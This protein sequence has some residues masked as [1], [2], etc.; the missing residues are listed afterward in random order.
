MI[1]D[2][3]ATIFLLIR[4]RDGAREEMQ[5]D[6]NCQSADSERSEQN[7]YGPHLSDWLKMRL[8]SL[9]A[10]Q[11][12]YGSADSAQKFSKIQVPTGELSEFLGGSCPP[13]TPGH[14]IP[15]PAM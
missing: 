3:F 13:S 11:A 9:K 1:A 15:D 14:V 5:G 7:F 2:F 4:P 6:R 12:S 8:H 10:Q